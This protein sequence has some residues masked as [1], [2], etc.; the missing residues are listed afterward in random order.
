MSIQSQIDRINGAK[1]DLVNSIEGKGVSVPEGVKIDDLATYVNAINSKGVVLIALTSDS[2]TLSADNL[3]KLKSTPEATVFSRGGY[4]YFA[5]NLSSSSTWYYS[6]NVY[7]SGNQIIKKVITITTSSGA[8][9]KSELPY[10]PAI[11]TKTS[12]LANDSGF[13][14]TT[15]VNNKIADLVGS[16]PAELDTLHELAAALNGDD[17]F[18]A[19]VL[20]KIGQKASQADLDNLSGDVE[21]LET[22]VGNKAN[23]ADLKTVAKTGSYND[24]NDK[25]T[26]PA[27]V[28]VDSTM[29][30]TSTN[31]VQ[32]KII[33]SALA[34]KAQL[35]GGNSFTGKQIFDASNSY[36]TVDTQK[37][38]VG[39]S[40]SAFV[41]GGDGLQC[42]SGINSTTGKV[43]YINY[44]GGDVIIG[45][46]GGSQ[47]INLQGTVKE[48]G[49]A[50][51]EKY[52]TN[53]KLEEVLG[54]YV[55]DIDALL[56]G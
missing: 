51:S 46:A 17:D 53:A 32:N 26:I 56:G 8:Y 27:A 25:P 47:S 28:T 16:A 14:T 6:C 1:Y 13:T 22:E 33:N 5:E 7:Y 2:G 48:N 40:S 55:N 37:F 42:F 49:T 29:S 43:F 3:A 50:L 34:G 20:N 44:Y 54:S 38:I 45:K 39:N 18:A 35:T 52:V 24:L 15:Y 4:Y 9:S 21:R 31:P 19:N 30:S 12:Q 23:D 10:S 41:I 36:N 11:P